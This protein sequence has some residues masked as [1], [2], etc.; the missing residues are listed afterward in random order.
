[1]FTSAQRNEERTTTNGHFCFSDRSGTSISSHGEPQ[2]NQHRQ[3][4]ED[5]IGD[6]AETAGGASRRCHSR[7]VARG[8]NA[9][10]E[11]GESGVEIRRGDGRETENVGRGRGEAGGVGEELAE[12]QVARRQGRNISTCLFRAV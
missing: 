6:V 12:E 11:C 5:D 10:T 3:G 1:M 2:R 7:N 8:I 4:A 9:Y